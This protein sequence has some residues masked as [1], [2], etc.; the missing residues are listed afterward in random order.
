MK[1]FRI[2]NSSKAEEVGFYPQVF[3]AVVNYDIY[4]ENSAYHLHFSK[5][6]EKTLWPICKLSGKAKKTDL[7]SISFT[8]LSNQLLVSSKLYSIIANNN[9]SSVQLIKSKLIINAKKQDEYWIINPI[10]SKISNLD[11]HNSTFAYLKSIGSTN[12]T[13]IRF[14]NMNDLIIEF[15]RNNQVAKSRNLENYKPFIID[16]VFINKACED[17]I[18]ALAPLDYAG[19]GYFVSEKIKKEIQAAG[20]TGIVFTES[21]EKYP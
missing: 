14:E 6:T 5:A 20:C 2:Y 19:I 11:I 15:D 7:I 9:S 12:K 3:N 1:F 8:S 4:D 21:N 17:D 10:I 16:E 13:F 18:F